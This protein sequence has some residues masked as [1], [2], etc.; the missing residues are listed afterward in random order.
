[1]RIAVILDEVWDSALTYYAYGVYKTLSKLHITKLVCLKDS[2]IDKKHDGDK[3]YIKDLRSKNLFKS[4]AGFKS[5]ARMFKLFKPDAVITIRGDA[6]FFSCLLKKK[7]KFK[8]IRIF[9]E[10][11]QLRTPRECI[12]TLILPNDFL[13][14]NVDEKKVGR[15]SVIKGFA[16]IETFKFNENA[17]ERIRRQ[18][19]ISDTQ[20][21]FGSVG[22]L[23]SIKGYP[24][25][26]RA[27]ANMDDS[28]KLMIVGEEKSQK[29]ENL[30]NIAE[31]VGIKSRI[32]IINERRSDIV[33]IMSAFDIGVIPSLGSEVIARVM[34][35]FMSVGLPIVTTDAGM[36]KEIAS[37]D[38]SVVAKAND[39][40]SLKEALQSIMQ[41]DLD[42]MRKSALWAA[43]KYSLGSFEN[44]ILSVIN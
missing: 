28:A 7:F 38:F 36:L 34:F 24:L 39:E 44:Q 8:L 3:I 5:L 23:D 33:D 26:I 40:S 13:K 31:D 17:R 12:D 30:L 42:K 15:I 9:G 32:I 2:Y 25:L 18:Y 16:D 4:V 27:F 10:D 6:T 20:I 11:K 19:G 35:E 37:D 41:K 1:M 29:R 22:R 14:A 21:L 43:E